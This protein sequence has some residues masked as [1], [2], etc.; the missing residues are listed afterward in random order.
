MSKRSQRSRALAEALEAVR[1]ATNDIDN[2]VGVTGQ[3]TEQL[4]C[5]RETVARA[6]QAFK[7]K[8]KPRSRTAWLA[9]VLILLEGENANEACDSLSDLLTHNGIYGENTGILDWSYRVE[10][11]EYL[12]PSTVSIPAD[13]EPDAI[14]LHRLSLAKGGA[15]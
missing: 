15:S 8:S 10:G 7:P 12:H 1:H 4:R 11:G 13:F 9:Q 5:L 6:E 2:A 14:E 3:F